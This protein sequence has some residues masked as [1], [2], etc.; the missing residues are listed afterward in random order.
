MKALNVPQWKSREI[1]TLFEDPQHARSE[2]K[3]SACEFALEQQDRA[4]VGRLNCLTTA[5]DG[6][7][8]YLASS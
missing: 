6:P 3:E 2:L 1:L 4:A 7:Q 5:W 8:N